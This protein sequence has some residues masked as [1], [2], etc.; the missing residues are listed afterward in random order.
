MAWSTPQLWSSISFTLT[1]PPKNKGL[2]VILF[3]NDWLER[4]RS[5]P[6]DVWVHDDR[7]LISREHYGP[8]IDA[9]NQHSGRWHTLCLYLYYPSFFGLFCGT[10]PPSNLRSLHLIS[11]YYWEKAVHFRMDSRPSPTRLTIDNFQALNIDIVWDNLRYLKAWDTGLDSC[12]EVIQRAPHL[13]SCSLLANFGRI[14]SPLPTTI[15]R[16]MYLRELE[17]F[18]FPAGKLIE[19]LNLMELPSLEEYRYDYHDPEFDGGDIA[20]GLVSLLNRS[21]C[22]LKCSNWSCASKP[23]LWKIYKSCSTPYHTSKNSI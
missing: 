1:K 12:L 10:S 18:D 17:L 9:L 2:N 3:I 14:S 21:G 22:H 11:I 4:S 6:L 20:A 23:Q 16:H 5:L 15:V 13:Q 8:I 19:F 7:H